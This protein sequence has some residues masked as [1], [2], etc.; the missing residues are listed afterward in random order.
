MCLTSRGQVRFTP[1]F[2]CGDLLP[3]FT[4]S[5]SGANVIDLLRKKMFVSLWVSSSSVETSFCFQ[6]EETKKSYE[7]QFTNYLIIKISSTYLLMLFPHLVTQ[8]ILH[9]CYVTLPLHQIQQSLVLRLQYVLTNWVWSQWSISLVASWHVFTDWSF[10]LFIF[11][12]WFARS[13]L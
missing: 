13:Y 10:H 1:V 7:T 11:L 3:T 4:P 12:I 8:N 9:S 2:I 6:P 5:H